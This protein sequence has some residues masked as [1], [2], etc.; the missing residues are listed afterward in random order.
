MEDVYLRV[1]NGINICRK[2]RME[3]EMSKEVN[4]NAGTRASVA[5]SGEVCA[6]DTPQA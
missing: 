5:S 6:R 1:S 2:E 3:A 4:F